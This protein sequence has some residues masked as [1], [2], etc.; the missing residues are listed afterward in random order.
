MDGPIPL[1][2]KT[3]I[4]IVVC[5]QTYGAYFGIPF[6]SVIFVNQSMA[7]HYEVITAGELNKFIIDICRHQRRVCVVFPV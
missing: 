7:I 5:L 3:G 6:S 1:T 4:A 2:C